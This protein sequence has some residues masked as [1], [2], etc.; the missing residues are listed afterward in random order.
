MGRPL[1][2]YRELLQP[3]AGI[4][5][6]VYLLGTSGPYQ[7]SVGGVG[8]YEVSHVE[9]IPLLGQ[10]GVIVLWYDTTLPPGYVADQNAITAAHIGA[11]S[12]ISLQPQAL[13]FSRGQVAQ[14]R[15]RPKFFAT[16]TGAVHD[17]DVQLY[18]PPSTQR[19]SFLHSNGVINTMGQVQDPADS[20]V[21]PA[22]GAD[23]GLPAAYASQY[24]WSGL[25]ARSEIFIAED[26]GPKIQ[27]NNNGSAITAGGAMG[28]EVSGF[29]YNLRPAT[30][31]SGSTPSAGYIAG[32][33]VSIP[34]GYSVNDIIP[35]PVANRD[36]LL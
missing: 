33:A 8:L 29:V 23:E 32:N 16:V 6:L 14:I 21:A 22:Q 7:M 5:D 28:I 19:F 15:M 35:L 25:A 3:V 2:L 30:M 24:A 27:L 9:P 12:N 34:P 36:P 17:Y 4:G 26:K 18:S 10:H 20:I 11:G 31:P 1:V 13:Q